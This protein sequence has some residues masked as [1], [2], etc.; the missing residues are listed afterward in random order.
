V[1]AKLGPLPPC[2]S[3]SVGSAAAIGW[4]VPRPCHSPPLSCRHPMPDVYGIR[5]QGRIIDC[6]SSLAVSGGREDLRLPAWGMGH[7][8]WLA[9]MS[10]LA[11]WVGC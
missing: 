5:Q 1:L 6:T 4:A 9:I 2:L 11:R 7:A 3:T 10:R 8:C